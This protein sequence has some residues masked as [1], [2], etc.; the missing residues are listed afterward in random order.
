MTLPCTLKYRNT[1][2]SPQESDTC[3]TP[4]G[5]VL[6]GKCQQTGVTMDSERGDG[7]AASVAGVEEISAGIDPALVGIITQR[8]CL[9]DA[10]QP[11][12][13]VDVKDSDRVVQTIDSV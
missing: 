12:I 13:R 9:A 11:S 7:I 8:G 3:R 2:H 6:S 4:Y 10:S 5:R 1:E